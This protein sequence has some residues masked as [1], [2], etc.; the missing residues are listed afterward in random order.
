MSKRSY[1]LP[2]LLEESVSR[3]GDR[4]A[5]TY[6]DA[7]PFS[8]RQ[9]SDLARKISFWLARHGIAKTDKI[10]ILGE[11]SPHWVAVF[12]GAVTMGAVTVSLLP[13]FSASEVNTILEHSDSKL[14]FISRRIWKRHQG[15]LTFPPE[16]V[17]IMDDF[18]LYK[19]NTD[20][21]QEADRPEFE[22]YEPEEVFPEDVANIIYTSG[23]TGRSKGVM[24]THENL[25]YEVEKV[26]L[27]QDV[28][29]QDIFL[30]LLPLSH[31]YENVLGMLLPLRQGASV[32]YM[33]KLPTP[34]VLVDAM[35][36]VKPTMILMV[37]LIIE[38]IYNT[39]ILPEL[40][41][42]GIMRG[43]MHVWPVNVFMNN[44]AGKRLMKAFGGRL[45]FLGVGGA[46]LSPR[47]EQFLRDARFPYSCG[48]GLT[49]T[50]SLIFASKVGKV[51]KQSVGKP[52]N[53]LEYRIIRPDR[54]SSEGEVVVKWKGNMKGYYK[55]PGLTSS[56]LTN[57]NWFHTG[58]LASLEN[59][60]L[61]LRGRSKTM[62]LGPSGENIYPEEIESVLNRMEGVIESL[63]YEV[64][65]KIV[66]KVYMNTDELSKKYSFFKES[67]QYHSGEVH[68]K[69]SHYLNT[70]RQKLNDHLG[71]YSQVYKV[72][73]VHRPFEKTPTHKIKRHL[74]KG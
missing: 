32:Y 3:F 26:L 18:T 11:N 1:T 4:R 41:K 31:V 49:E 29:E 48:Y 15:K 36:K 39:K 71:R 74:Y 60:N 9:L 46:P 72:E 23:T 43:M 42:N 69:I 12:W 7:S 54:K 50:S 56:V 47:T 16:N 44:M 65:G 30:S 40:T 8:Y 2:A 68:Q 70:M 55:E 17:V 6:I 24:L 22:V 14:L 28:N 13:D 62:I 38:K 58:D 59:G 21:L 35:G 37:P 19:D 34:S 5:V 53:G 64:K 61:Y 51:K 25:T 20:I 63:V 27:V 67:A 66:A 45:R 10:A 33:S 57:G 73:L 52:L